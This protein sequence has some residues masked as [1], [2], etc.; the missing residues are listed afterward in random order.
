MGVCIPRHG[1]LNTG[2]AYGFRPQILMVT[3]TAYFFLGLCNP[4]IHEY[5][6]ASS[7]GGS[8]G[9][10]SWWAGWRGQPQLGDA[11]PVLTITPQKTGLNC[12]S[13]TCPTGGAPNINYGKN[14]YGKNNYGKTGQ[15]LISQEKSIME[16][17][18]L[19]KKKRFG[20]LPG[21]FEPLWGKT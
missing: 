19:W 1:H 2:D 21:Y 5:L 8:L 15:S 10:R 11:V 20:S 7:H 12:G 16:K 3:Y 17:M 13:M 9:R 6:W 18:E 4:K 14:N